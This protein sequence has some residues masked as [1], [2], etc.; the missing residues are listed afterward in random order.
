MC[1]PSLQNET[2]E[3]PPPKLDLL[4]TIKKEAGEERPGKSAK[5][6]L[7]ERLSE[8]AIPKAKDLVEGKL[9]KRLQLQTWIL[10]LRTVKEGRDFAGKTGEE[11]SGELSAALSR[12]L[13][14]LSEN[15]KP[16]V[17][18]LPRDIDREVR[19]EFKKI[20]PPSDATLEQG[21]NAMFHESS[22][23]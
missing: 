7:A 2:D 21:R 18:L 5:E 11:V 20:L 10:A 13:T 23:G 15:P 14:R 9:E 6:V 3:S 8:R 1:T 19:P 22:L 17:R 4:A 12:P 16:L